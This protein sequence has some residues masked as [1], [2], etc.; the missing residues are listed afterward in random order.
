MWDASGESVGGSTKSGQLQT[1]A[2]TDILL[3]LRRTSRQIVERVSGG[4]SVVGWYVE[5][6]D[7]ALQRLGLLSLLQ[8]LYKI[9]GLE[10]PVALSISV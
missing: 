1:T 2:G 5:L 9:G 3:L 8:T 10:D 4:R 7:G 6:L